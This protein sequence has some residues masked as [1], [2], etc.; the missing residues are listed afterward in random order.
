MKKILVHNE[1]RNTQSGNCIP[2]EEISILHTTSTIE[3]PN[4]ENIINATS[5]LGKL[6]E[7]TDEDPA[8]ADYLHDD[9]CFLNIEITSELSDTIVEY[10]AGYIVK[11]LKKIIHCEDCG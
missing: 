3:P 11:R 4:P 8:L 10:I 9:N 7:E 2:L 5:R 6:I 1:I